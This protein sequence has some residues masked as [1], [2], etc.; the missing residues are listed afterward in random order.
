MQSLGSLGY[1]AKSSWPASAAC[2]LLPLR[3]LLGVPPGSAPDLG[4]ALR[5][6]TS[7][8]YSDCGETYWEAPEGVAAPTP[9]PV[10]APEG[11]QAAPR[12]AREQ[13]TDRL[14]QLAMA[15]VRLQPAPVQ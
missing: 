8:D 12:S 15:M 9:E 3:R 11:A 2:A 6:L 14:L 7:A 4:G 13:E 5:T 10:Q 1:S